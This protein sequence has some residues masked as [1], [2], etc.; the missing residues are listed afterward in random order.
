M[1][2][3]VNVQVMHDCLII[4]RQEPQPELPAEP[5]VVSS[6]KQ[7]CKK[8]SDRKLWGIAAYVELVVTPQKRPRRILKGTV[9]G[10]GWI[11]WLIRQVKDPDLVWSE[12]LIFTMEI[13]AFLEFDSFQE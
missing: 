2:T 13:V 7:T 6:L 5:E 3:P 1:G 11:K 12:S 8:L 4:T 10:V 9:G